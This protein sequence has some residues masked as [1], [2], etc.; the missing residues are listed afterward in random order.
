MSTY[1]TYFHLLLDPDP[2]MFFSLTYYHKGLL[3]W[4]NGEVGRTE[5]GALS[6]LEKVKDKNKKHLKGMHEIQ[7]GEMYIAWMERPYSGWYVFKYQ[8]WGVGVD[9]DSGVE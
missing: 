8:L 6:S 2:V 9:T 1:V 4:E 7:T 3:W 5:Y